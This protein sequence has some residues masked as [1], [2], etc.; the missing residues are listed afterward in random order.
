MKHY[1][2]R[3]FHL[4]LLVVVTVTTALG[5]QPRNIPQPNGEPVTLDSWKN[6]IIFVILPVLAFVFYMIWKRQKQKNK[7]RKD[8]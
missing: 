8:P 7:D 2:H 1:T 3:L 5:Q 4:L 6:I